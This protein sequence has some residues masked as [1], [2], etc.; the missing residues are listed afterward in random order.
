MKSVT[1]YLAVTVLLAMFSLCLSPQALAAIWTRQMGTYAG[2]EAAGVATDGIGNVYVTG[3]TSGDLDGNTG[4]GLDDLFVVKYGTDGNK[5]WTRQMGPARA[6]GVTTDVGG[7]VYVCGRTHGGLDGYKNPDP[8][9]NSDDL[10]V[11]KYDTYGNKLW[12][13][14]MGSKSSDYAA[15]VATDG[16]GNVYVTGSTWGALDGN[17]NDGNRQNRFIIKYDTNGNRLWTKQSAS[18]DIGGVATD[19]SGNVYVAGGGYYTYVIKYDTNGNVIWSKS[20]GSAS[21]GTASNLAYGVATDGNGNVYIA[22]CTLGGLDGNA[23]AGWFDFYVAKYNSAGVKQWLRQAGTAGDDRACGVSA[24]GNGNVYAVGYTD[25]RLPGNTKAGAL[26]IFVAKYDTNGVKQWIRQRGTTSDDKATGVATDANGNAYV[27][28]W[29]GGGLDGNTITS[30]YHD[31]FV[32]KLGQLDVTINLPDS[33]TVAIDPPSDNGRYA[34]GTVVTLTE[35]PA[36]GYVFLGWSGD[37]TGTKNTVSLTMNKDYVVK[38]NFKKVELFITPSHTQDASKVTLSATF[39]VNGLPASGKS[40][41]FYEKTGTSAPVLKGS[42][43]T[44]AD[45]VATKTFVSTAGAHTAYVKYTS[46]TAVPI[47]QPDGAIGIAGAPGMQS[48]DYSYTTYKVTVITPADK[49]VVTSPMPTLSWNP[50]DEASN[51]H[52][53]VATATTFGLTTILQEGDTADTSLTISNPLLIGKTYYWRVQAT[54][55]G[56]KSIWSD[57]RRVIYKYGTSISLE[58]LGK[59]G[60]TLKVRAT[61]MK[62]DGGT[63]VPG[64]TLT[65]YEN[66]NGGAFVSKGT[67]VTG[68]ALSIAPG[69]ANKAWIPT[70]LPHAA[71]VKFLGDATC[72][73]CQTDPAAVSY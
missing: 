42:A 52:V 12:T 66:T 3:F 63:P 69:V 9:G 41:S 57:Y 70:A 22:G 36:L 34:P 50:L 11:V 2:A 44:N 62:T 14:Q 48:A 29:T 55:P 38:A 4:T 59:T 6:T 67:A 61:L 28:G 1:R 27:A 46:P 23:Y 47:E 37:A 10:F 16:S 68:G 17:T 39:N 30:F 40:I 15:A 31:L 58:N 21:L 33:G 60:T 65:F 54:I 73:P 25:S 35:T 24:D 26:D 71:Y 19:G 53:Q 5:L 72:A 49:A 56:G 18:G 45:G 51:Y 13:R 20:L 32:M 64:K 43:T 7:N 8:T